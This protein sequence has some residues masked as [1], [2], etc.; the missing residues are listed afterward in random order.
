VAA[1]AALLLGGHTPYRQWVVYRRKHLLI[2]CHR[3]DLRTYDLAQRTVLQLVQHLP[4]SRA[5]VA[6]APNAGRLASLLGTEQMDVAVLSASDAH[7]MLSG[8]GGFEPYGPIG[9]SLLT[10]IA[11]RLLVARADFPARHAW[12]VAGALIGTPLAPA[13]APAADHGVPW[14]AGSQAF[15]SG[16]REPSEASEAA[17]E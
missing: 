12:L 16:E 1:A 2:G 9:L 11:D 4:S 8:A 6:R 17:Q 15:L 3:E 14:H 10:P 7:A 5:R 13:P